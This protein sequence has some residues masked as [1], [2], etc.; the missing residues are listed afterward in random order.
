M[1]R[2][3]LPESRGVGRPVGCPEG[4]LYVRVHG[5]LLGFPPVARTASARRGE[6]LRQNTPCHSIV[7]I[8]TF[9]HA[10]LESRGVGRPVGCP[11][12]P[13]YV[14]VHGALLGFP[15]VTRT[16]SARRGEHLRQNTPC[17]SIV[18]I[19]TFY[20]ADLFIVPSPWQLV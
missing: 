15:P 16:A 10:L 14:R 3:A 6:H 8:F 11:E 20:P 2:H 4:P 17:H 12:G 9:D 19:F 18:L 13:L 7:L 5:A 1:H